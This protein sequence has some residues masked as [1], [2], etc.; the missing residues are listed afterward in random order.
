VKTGPESAAESAPAPAPAPA[1]TELP[2]PESPKSIYRYQAAGMA[3]HKGAIPW[4]LWIVA[5]LLAIWSVY[6]VIVYWNPP[7]P[8]H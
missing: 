6:Y 2:A 5:I 3:E 1:E 4:W 7:V 8:P